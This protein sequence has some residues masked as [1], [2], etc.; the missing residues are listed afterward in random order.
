MLIIFLNNY[1]YFSPFS[2]SAETS[3]TASPARAPGIS[4][5][6]G[7]RASIKDRLRLGRDC[8][9]STTATINRTGPNIGPGSRG[10]NGDK[11]GDIFLRESKTVV[12][13]RLRNEIN[14]RIV[15]RRDMAQ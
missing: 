15:R 6:T 10:A 4:F 5:A 9:E 1:I 7:S 8:R 13:F 12:L 3:R 2:P 11:R 14:G